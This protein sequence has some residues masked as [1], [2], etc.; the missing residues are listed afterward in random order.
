MRYQ[1]KELGIRRL[2]VGLGLVTGIGLLV[3]VFFSE[4]P[5]NL[6]DFLPAAGVCVVAGILVWG[7]VRLIYWVY[8]GF[9]A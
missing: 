3:V 8:K 5:W 1:G 2:A 7:L 6:S 9:R 4:S